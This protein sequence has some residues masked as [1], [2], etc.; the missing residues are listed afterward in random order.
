MLTLVLLNDDILFVQ[1]GYIGINYATLYFQLIG[2]KF[3]I[4]C[5]GSVILKV[6]P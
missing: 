3:Y 2:M 1:E 4:G 6:L 5:T